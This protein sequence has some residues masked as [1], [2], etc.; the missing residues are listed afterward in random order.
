[1]SF[2]ETN[3]KP[4]PPAAYPSSGSGHAFLARP[5]KVDNPFDKLRVIGAPLSPS[6]HL[7]AAEPLRRHSGQSGFRAHRV[8]TSAALSTGSVRT[9]V[10]GADFPRIPSEAENKKAA[11]EEHDHSVCQDGGHGKSHP[12]RRFGCLLS[13]CEL[14]YQVSTS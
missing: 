3:I 9:E 14:L 12:L 2:A 10:R 6:I 7:L 13:T 4:L 5:R 11:C 1:M 8:R